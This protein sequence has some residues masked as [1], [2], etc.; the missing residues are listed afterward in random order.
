MSSV[1]DDTVGNKRI[2][3]EKEIQ[4]RK[5]EEMVEMQNSIGRAKTPGRASDTTA[6]QTDV[7]RPQAEHRR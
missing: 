6:A 1:V 5:M 4:G 7:R 2:R 3:E